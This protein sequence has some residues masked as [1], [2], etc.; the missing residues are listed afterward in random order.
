M[1]SVPS[2]KVNRKISPSVRKKGDAFGRWRNRKEARQS[3]R[4]AKGLTD[5]ARGR[6]SILITLN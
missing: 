3:L 5:P 6:L 2:R 4:E 1:A